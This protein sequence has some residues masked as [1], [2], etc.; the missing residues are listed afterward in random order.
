MPTIGMPVTARIVSAV[1]HQSGKC[2]GSNVVSATCSTMKMPTRYAPSTLNTFRRRSSEANLWMPADPATARYN[3]CRVNRSHGRT[4][5]RERLDSARSARTRAGP[6]RR[7]NAGPR[8]CRRAGCA[9]RASPHGASR[10]WPAGRARPGRSESA[11]RRLR[12]VALR[13]TSGCGLWGKAMGS[14]TVPLNAAESWLNDP[15]AQS[16]PTFEV[17]GVHDHRP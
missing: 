10:R 3:P 2:S 9:V 12:R 5:L 8:A 4:R 13:A 14:A 6:P 11:G 1:I 17:A 15:V 7:C 16:K